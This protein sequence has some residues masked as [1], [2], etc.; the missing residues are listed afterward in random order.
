VLLIIV[1]LLVA[2]IVT[3]LIDLTL[4]ERVRF[5]VKIAVY[6]LT[7]LWVIYTLFVSKVI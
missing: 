6:L 2:Y 1:I 3:P 4:N 5:F 7:L